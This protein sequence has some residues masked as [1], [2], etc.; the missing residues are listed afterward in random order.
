MLL[1]VG[2]MSMVV[3][4]RAESNLLENSPFLP[5]DTIAHTTQQSA[6]LELRSIVKEDGQY[7][8]SL[9]DSAKK[10]STWVRLNEPG[11]EFRVKTFDPANNAVTVEQQGRIYTLALK[12]AKISLLA[13]F[14]TPPVVNSVSSTPAARRNPQDIKNE[15]AVLQ[16]R[17][18]AASKHPPDAVLPSPPQLGQQESQDN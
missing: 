14:Q 1:S 9:Y 3:L 11:S 18:F 17:M 7:E 8:F 2:L 13:A 10:Q 5:P 16:L 4:A 6:P 12:D 15:L